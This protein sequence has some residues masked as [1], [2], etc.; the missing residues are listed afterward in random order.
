MK[1][2]ILNKMQS[3]AT[4]AIGWTW[5]PLMLL[6]GFLFVGSKFMQWIGLSS[7][8]FGE[9][10][11]TAGY[12]RSIDNSVFFF[13]ITNQHC[14]S[15]IQNISFSKI[16]WKPT[17]R[18]H[19][20]INRRCQ[21]SFI[22]CY[23]E[24]HVTLRITTQTKLSPC[25]TTVAKPHIRDRDRVSKCIESRKATTRHSQNDSTLHPSF[26]LSI[27]PPSKPSNIPRVSSVRGSIDPSCRLWADRSRVFVAT[28]KHVAAIRKGRELRR[29][30]QQDLL[31]QQQAV[32]PACMKNAIQLGKFTFMQDA[33][34]DD[35]QDLVK[36]HLMG[37]EW[38]TEDHIWDLLFSAAC[39]LHSLTLCRIDASASLCLAFWL[40][41]IHR[42]CAAAAAGNPSPSRSREMELESD[43]QVTSAKASSG[44]HNWLII[45]V[46]RID[47]RVNVLVWL[48]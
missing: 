23:W 3:K 4:Y 13:F 45:F 48:S 40:R 37:V 30:Q 11:K 46:L 44:G 29:Q 17:L 38:G 35:V 39:I 24:R 14:I 43:A 26:S 18:W 28:W 47:S 27:P 34:S 1:E 42:R 2:D 5:R 22:V 16:L 31:P 21:L 36:W 20:G 12:L 25:M 8:T 10:C 15:I 7:S 6:C 41:K 9:T 33:S 19:F 32:K